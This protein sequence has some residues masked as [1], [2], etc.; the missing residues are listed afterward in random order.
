MQRGFRQ[1]PLHE[2]PAG[3]QLGPEIGGGIAGR[4]LVLRHFRHARPHVAEHDQPE[5][6]HVVG[7]AAVFCNV[8]VLSKD[9]ALVEWDPRTRNVFVKDPDGLNLELVGT[10]PAAASN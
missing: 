7:G 10:L 9:G 4:N 1:H 3:D 8:P 6:F 5:Q 2:E